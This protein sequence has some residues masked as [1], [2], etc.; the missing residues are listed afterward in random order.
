[1]K[2]A[3]SLVE[4]IDPPAEIA[5]LDDDPEAIAARI[6]AA[7]ADA[8]EHATQASNHWSAATA[9]ALEIGAMLVRFREKVPKGHYEAELKRLCDLAPRTARAYVRLHQK[10]KAMPEH[11]RQRVAAMPV[12]QALLTIATAAEPLPRGHLPSYRPASRAEAD[13]VAARARRAVTGMNRSLLKFAKTVD[14]GCEVTGSDMSRLK[15]QVMRVHNL[16]CVLAPNA[17]AAN[18]GAE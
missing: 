4:R 10:F 14:A 2:A 16:P 9:K 17:D 15:A 5:V 3:L 7:V 12:R 18:E 1:V 11:Q 8:N 13:L 6:N